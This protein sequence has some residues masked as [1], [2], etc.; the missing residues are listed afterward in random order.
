MR[1]ICVVTSQASRPWHPAALQ[2]ARAPESALRD[3]LLAGDEIQF[4]RFIEQRY[5]GMKRI[6][7]CAADPRE[8]TTL[9]QQAVIDFCSEL[10]SG[11][12]DGSVDAELFGCLIRR[13]RARAAELGASDPFELDE[14]LEPAVAS[15]RF[16]GDEHRWGGGWVEPPRPFS[17]EALAPPALT[18]LPRV[19]ASGLDRLSPALV[20]VAVLRDMQGLT[21]SE[22]GRLLSLPEPKVRERLHRARSRVRFELE[23]YL[24]R[25]ATQEAR[26]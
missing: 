25:G 3:A 15:D 24:S 23:T 13:L 20:V 21:S 1:A 14:P 12:T 4:E 18:E 5:A 19:L 10:A 17:L 16:R 7:S 9:V 26:S 6:A 11:E 8:A 2:P 22:I